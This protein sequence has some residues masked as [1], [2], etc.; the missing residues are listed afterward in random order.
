MVKLRLEY[1]G[2]MFYHLGSM[3]GHLIK[4]LRV[5]IYNF[6]FIFLYNILMLF[7][8]F[9]ADHKNLLGYPL[10]TIHLCSIYAHKRNSDINQ[11]VDV[12]YLVFSK[13]KHQC[14]KYISKIRHQFGTGFFFQCSK[15]TN[16]NNVNKS[17]A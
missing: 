8:N 11:C 6:S 16:Q 1:L 17:Y 2:L 4:G 9:S 7:L 3:L 5:V 13:S 12:H 14:L 15:R 10:G